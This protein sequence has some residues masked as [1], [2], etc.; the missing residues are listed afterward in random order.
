MNKEIFFE[1]FKINLLYAD[2]KITSAY[3]KKK[4]YVENPDKLYKKIFLST[5]VYSPLIMI[6]VY[7]F[8]F[9]SFNFKQ[10]PILFDYFYLFFIVFGL[11]NSFS[12]TYNVF[13]A[14]KDLDAYKS[15]PIDI[16]DLLKSKVLVIFVSLL[17]YTVPIFIILVL[18]YLKSGFNIVELILYP[19]LIFIITNI[20]LLAVSIF[21]I[22]VLMKSMIIARV[23]NSFITFINIFSFLIN[24]LLFLGFHSFKESLS[25]I[26][27]GKSGLLSEIIMDRI[28]L[29]P[30]LVILTFI[31]IIVCKKTVSSIGKTYFEDNEKINDSIKIK[32]YKK[33]KLPFLIKYNLDL[34]FKDSS[35][36]TSSVI[37]SSILPILYIFPALIKF[38]NFSNINDL[39][40]TIGIAGLIPIFQ[41]MY[42]SNLSSIIISLDRENFNYIKALPINMKS[43][44][45]NK[46]F[47]SVF[48]N[49]VVPLIFYLC[50]MIYLKMSIISVIC[51]IAI[52]IV[53]AASFAAIWMSFDY[54]NFL[55]T[56]QSVTELTSRAGK[57]WTFIMIVVFVLLFGLFMFLVTM[58]SII[59]DYT[60][61]FYVVIFIIILCV[62][63]IKFKDLVNSLER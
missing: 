12:V 33:S 18:F 47:V 57:L 14:S 23:G 15:L 39:L 40:I 5:F 9:F 59:G 63:Y 4:K 43:Y 48:V 7:G 58:F 30:I 32:K 49:G 31:S 24:I 25:I 2:S 13:Y 62:G 35:V 26:F 8:V 45:L 21:V 46:L 54:E 51:G 61:M 42:S 1:I 52:Y 34:I 10:I 19:V 16:M 53:I 60:L 6:V 55:D 28:Y 11:V 27:Y 44:I 38:K 37:T 50:F 41:Y 56:W 17:T 22:N 29:V 20:F 36:I 3:S